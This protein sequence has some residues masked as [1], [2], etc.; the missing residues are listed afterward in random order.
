MPADLVIGLDC[1]TT[2]ATAVVWAQDGTPCAQAQ[3]CVRTSV[4]ALGLA[5]Q[6][7]AEWWS[8]SVRA[9]RECSAAV[10]AE[11]IRALGLTWQRETFA[12]L[13][14]AGVPVRPAILWYDAR[15]TEQVGRLAEAMDPTE[16]LRR[17]GK[18]LDITSALP[19]LLWLHERESTSVAG[20]HAFADVGG[21][22]SQCL[23]GRLRTA[24]AGVDTTGLV[25][26]RQGTWLRE[27]L[28][29]VGAGSLQ[30]PELVASVEVAG[31]LATAAAGATGLA[32]GLPVVL[33]GGDGHCF[34]LGA[35]AA[36]GGAQVATLTLGTSAVLGLDLSRPVTGDAF[37]T[38]I[39]CQPGRFLLE[40]VIQCGGATLAWHDD[41]FAN[42]GSSPRS[43]SEWNAECSRVPPGSLG[44]IVLPHWR[45]QRVPA[46]DPLAR[47]LAIGWH[48]GHT[49][50]AFRRAIMEGIAIELRQL[51]ALMSQT[52]GAEACRLVAGGGGAR[53]D[54]WCQILADVL[55]IPV[56]RPATVELTALGAAL[57]ARAAVE[58]GGD[59]AAA[60]RGVRLDSS[61]FAPVPAATAVYTELATVQAE[62]YA[63]NKDLCHRLAAIAAQPSQAT[64]RQ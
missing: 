53:A 23:T 36:A 21:Y 47:G 3:A 60:R 15:A 33:A 38:L 48:D 22:L 29:R 20:A 30:L 54:L 32:R 24:R 39:S 49:A 5:E 56:I 17:T 25:D 18:Q 50:A 35:A 41:V 9:L 51:L 44:L 12:L 57:C 43:P 45:G 28:S 8:A 4:P 27:H 34:A 10:G 61:R 63:R 55:A 13:D 42:Q 19:K 40:S 46:N 59:L 26:L 1:S 7:P 14:S 58:F 2:A 52:T 62:L 37:R 31:E 6:D 64:P 16:H 11:R